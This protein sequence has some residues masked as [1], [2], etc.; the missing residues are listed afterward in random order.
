MNALSALYKTLPKNMKA[1]L[2]YKAL[3]MGE[4]PIK[5]ALNI[6]TEMVTSKLSVTNQSNLSRTKPDK[7]STAKSSSADD[8]LKINLT[9]VLMLQAGL[10]EREPITLQNETKYRI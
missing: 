7:A 4:E 2:E 1:L 5:G 10:T 8:P 3:E 9:P 6:L